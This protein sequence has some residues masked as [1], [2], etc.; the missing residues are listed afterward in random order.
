MTTRPV[1]IS[2][3]FGFDAAH[4]FEHPGA[5][6]SYRRMH[7]HSFAAEVTIL[8]VPDPE[9]GFVADFAVLES[10]TAALRS[11][12]DHALLNDVPGLAVPSLENIAVWIWDRLLPRFPGLIRVV[13]RRPSCRQSC[14]YRGATRGNQSLGSAPD[15]TVATPQN[16]AI[17]SK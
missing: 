12:L 11:E 13:V 1:E 6:P 14:T 2:L 5:D 4:C 7:G 10:S 8:G 3:E 16:V 15:S 17:A 9:S